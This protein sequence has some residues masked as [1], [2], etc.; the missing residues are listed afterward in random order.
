MITLIFRKS[1]LDGSLWKLNKKALRF[2][3]DRPA[4]EPIRIVFEK[5]LDRSVISFIL[6]DFLT[7]TTC[8][9]KI[10]TE[11]TEKLLAHFKGKQDT[12]WVAPTQI[13]DILDDALANGRQV[14]FKAINDETG[15]E[16]T[17]PS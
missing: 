4:L 13:I 17:L 7:F 6:V 12:Y 10:E 8:P 9:L 16:T 5:G 1:V 14:S 15:Q 11:A 2:C 3:Q